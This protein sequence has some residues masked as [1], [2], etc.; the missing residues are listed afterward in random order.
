MNPD[1]TFV[2]LLELCAPANVFVSPEAHSVRLP[3]CLAAARGGASHSDAR[4]AHR[5]HSQRPFA[6]AFTEAKGRPR[7]ESYSLLTVRRFRPLARRRLR[8]SRPFLV[9]MRTRNPCV[10]FRWRVLGWNVRLPFMCA[11]DGVESQAIAPADRQRRRKRMR[12]TDNVSEGVRK[13]STRLL[14]VR[15]GVLHH[16]NRRRPAMYV[17]SLPRVFHT[18]GKN[19]GNSN[20]SVAH[21][22]FRLRFGDIF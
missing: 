18:C 15:V 16:R 3:A 9:L 20:R 21:R 17:W 2:R 5:R 7:P 12:R 4:L 22:G 19:C 14:C 11:P 6:E 1:P 10:R 8:T 13:V